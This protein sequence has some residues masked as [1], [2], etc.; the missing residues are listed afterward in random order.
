[1]RTLLTASGLG[2]RTFCPVAVV[3]C[4]AACTDNATPPGDLDP[5]GAA[6]C[7]PNIDGVIERD[8][9]I[10]IGLTN[11]VVLASMPGTM[12]SVDV[13]GVVDGD[14]TITWPFAS[15]AL[16]ITPTQVVA[17]PVATKWYASSFPGAQYAF[18]TTDGAFDFVYSQT[19]DAIYLH[20]SASSLESPTTGQTLIAYTNPIEIYRFPLYR[21]WSA[22][23]VA[24]IPS[25]SV[26]NG[27]P[28]MGTDLYQ[29]VD[30]ATGY[31]ELPDLTLTQAH[32]VRFTITNR[33][34]GLPEIVRR[35]VSFL[36]EC[37]GEVARVTSQ[38]GEPTEDFTTAADVRRFTVRRP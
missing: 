8:E 35:Q 19:P 24:E 33:P 7:T 3:G 21:G 23:M 5:P 1:M 4:L 27:F 15:D 30:D 11:T 29:I 31:I 12:T 17:E 38:L 2:P 37:F 26:F 22:T 34:D 18:T 25:G 14:G 16:G 28:F 36:F 6:R 32:R 9:Y 20:G 13:K 10:N